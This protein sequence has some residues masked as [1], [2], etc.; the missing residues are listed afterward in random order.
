MNKKRIVVKVGT[1]TL[2]HDNG[3]LNF[4]RIDKLVQVLSDLRNMGNDVI[5]V[6]S[7]A[8][9][10]G[11]S[12]IKIKSE[13]RTM[14]EKQAAAAIGMCELMFLYEKLFIQYGN[15]TAQILLT[16]DI[17]D[18]KVG[19]ENVINTINTLLEWGLIPVIN[20]NDSV[21]FEEIEFGDND[22]LSALVSVLASAD[23]LILMTD[24]DG[25]YDKNPRENPDA[26]LISKVSEITE[27]LKENAGGAGTRRGTGGMITKLLAAEIAMENNID[28][29]IVNGENP[30]NI[31]S[32]VK[33]EM[34]GT[35][36]TTK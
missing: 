3:K 5:L 28:M 21:A 11:L 23:L 27:T 6:T 4:Q 14:R 32:A 36:F 24:I 9:G 29:Y 30:D 34:V 1:S 13:E 35:L 16:K 15:N 8:V 25:L 7:G 33:G 12:K 31:Y 18:N 19:K 17:T 22:T 2:T 10:V 26:K 20:Q